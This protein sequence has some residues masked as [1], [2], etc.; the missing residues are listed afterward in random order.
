MFVTAVCHLDNARRYPRHFTSETIASIM[1][2]YD[3]YP[4]RKLPQYIKNL[5]RTQ[6]IVFERR[7][8]TAQEMRETMIDAYEHRKYYHEETI[9][10]LFN[11]YVRKPN[12]E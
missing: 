6:R 4:F 9:D 8:P 3:D 10:D 1:L 5:L 11:F 7:V 12:D 2:Q